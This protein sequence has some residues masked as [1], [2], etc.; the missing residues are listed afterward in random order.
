MLPTWP[1]AELMGFDLETTGVD[2]F[3]DVPVSFA[4]VRVVGG[5]LVE[6]VS[7]VVNPG[8]PIPPEASAIHGITDE[9]AHDEGMPLREAIDRMAAALIDATHR[10]VPVAGM[11]LDFDLTIT[12]WQCRRLTGRGLATRGW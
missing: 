12:D 5:Q 4:I 10:A 9:R 7:S 1:E 2:R 3:S 8:R 11:R 6:R